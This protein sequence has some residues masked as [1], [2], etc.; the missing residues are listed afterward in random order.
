MELPSTEHA[1]GGRDSGQEIIEE[2]DEQ[3]ELEWREQ[4][5]VRLRENKTKEAVERQQIQ[6]NNSDKDIWALLDQ[7]EMMEELENELQ[8]LEVNDDSELMKHLYEMN[9]N[10]GNGDGDSGESG[11]VRNVPTNEVDADEIGTKQFNMLRM[12]AEKLSDADKI[13]FYEK[14]LEELSEQLAKKNGNDMNE[15]AEMRITGGCLQEAIAEIREEM[16]DSDDESDHMDTQSSNDSLNVATETSNKPTN[17]DAPKAQIVKKSPECRKYASCA[18]YEQVEREYERMEKSKSELLIFYKSQLRSVMK[19]I[20]G[21]SSDLLARD[22]K[23]AMYEFITNRIDQ[24]RIDIHIEKQKKAEEDFVDDDDDMDHHRPSNGRLFNLNLNRPNC[25]FNDDEDND[26]DENNDDDCEEDSKRR[27][28]FAIEP[29]ITTFHEDDEPWRVQIESN[30]ESFSDFIDDKFQFFAS[31]TVEGFDDYT[32]EL[33]FNDIPYVTEEAHDV[34][35]TNEDAKQFYG[36]QNGNATNGSFKRT[37]S[38]STDESSEQSPSI[39][40]S[41]SSTASPPTA[42]PPRTS[43]PPPLI[44][45][46][47]HSTNVRLNRPSTEKGFIDSP[48]DIYAQ[49]GVASGQHDDADITASDDNIKHPTSMETMQNETS[50]MIF[51]KTNNMCEDVNMNTGSKERTIDINVNDRRAYNDNESVAQL[52]AVAAASVE[53]IIPNADVKP[54]KSILKNRAAVQEEIHQSLSDDDDEDED[55]MYDFR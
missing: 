30:R 21:A 51:T 47:E 39:S 38:T 2:Y 33:Y 44:V 10:P 26:D 25:R 24:L 13:Q 6:N 23:R 18:D 1:F 54:V 8:Q 29:V 53:P 9:M 28:K 22:R 27:I 43:S 40:S 3:K 11:N 48:L 5:R 17:T 4:H 12:E 42:S 31:P 37:L 35:T 20:A 49:F 32:N 46:F 14:H 16:D 55:G 45:E 52:P 7:A 19:S 15:L 41:T 34:P 50:H 36:G